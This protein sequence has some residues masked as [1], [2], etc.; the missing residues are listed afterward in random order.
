V[1]EAQT[2]RWIRPSRLT[3]AAA[4]AIAAV[5]AFSAAFLIARYP[6]LPELLPVRFGRSGGPNG[7]QFKTLP[8][9]LMPVFVQTALALVLGGIGALVL[10]RSHT[11]H[12]EGATDVRAA[13]V[14]AE[15][16]ALMTLIWVTFQAYGAVALVGMWQR[17]RG[18][19]GRLY[20]Y[21]EVVGVLLTVAVALR[22]HARA[23]RPERRP[24]VADHWR[25][26][27][28]Y[29]NPDDPALSSRRATAPAGP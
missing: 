12:D 23:G 20:S 7:W 16:V 22:A 24:F 19:L 14:A 13:S 21:L 15:S 17:E 18:G 3:L 11:A 2:V 10:S 29:R 25:F 28:L 8:R 6:E 5:I 4:I 26:G 1:S 9:V 27:Q